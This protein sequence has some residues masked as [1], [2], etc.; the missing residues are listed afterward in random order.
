MRD[1]KLSEC[2]LIQAGADGVEIGNNNID[3]LLGKTAAIL[4]PEHELAISGGK[5]G[6]DAALM[7]GGED[8]VGFDGF[9][10]RHFPE[11]VG[12]VTS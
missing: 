7:A 6:A 3:P 4:R 12:N 9:R 11:I 2:E 8:A 1:A 10:P 5:D